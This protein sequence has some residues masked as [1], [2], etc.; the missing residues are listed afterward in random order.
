M[1]ND[2]AIQRIV[3]AFLFACAMTI[4]LLES[5]PELRHP[6][7]S[8]FLVAGLLILARQV[9]HQVRS[10]PHVRIR[11]LL[12][13]KRSIAQK[14]IGEIEANPQHGYSILGL[15]EETQPRHRQN[16]PCLILGTINELQTIVS[17]V[18][19]HRIILALSERRG[20][21]LTGQL[22]E[23]QMNGIVVEDAVGAYERLSGKLA[24]EALTPM[25]MISTQGFGK[26]G[27]LRAGQRAVSFAVALMGLGLL[28]PVLALIA[29]AIKL[30]SPGPV[31][32]RQKRL[33]KGGRPFQLIKFRTM[34]QVEQPRSEWAEDNLDRITRVGR[35]L[36]RFR[37]D[38]LPQMVNVIRGDMNLVGP[39]PHPICNFP[40][41]REAIPYYVLRCSVRPGITGWAQVRYR[42]ANNLEQET[43]K[44]R[45]DLY[46]IKHMSL[47][48]DLRILLK[49]CGIVLSAFRSLH[50]EYR[51]R[52]RRGLRHAPAR[53]PA[54]WI[55]ELAPPPALTSQPRRAA[56]S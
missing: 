32:F 55:P 33:G 19:P 48:L 43:E 22:L 53:L 20:R 28:A 8:S 25:Q 56:V 29:L 44:M 37:L 30:D 27:A 47:W 2:V 35:W 49:T 17:A 5:V 41:F 40:L 11:V 23:L 39:R 6:F 31:L 46:Y 42:Y 1:S 26:S 9:T 50:G 12:I 24:V 13:G 21:I 18:R 10:S 34:R 16:C 45:Y 3:G 7:A 38:E 15:V 4:A 52:S 14:F 51:R 54:G 36:R